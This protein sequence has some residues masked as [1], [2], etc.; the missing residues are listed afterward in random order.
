MMNNRKTV[1][2]SIVL[3]SAVGLALYVVSAMRGIPQT[4]SA[5]GSSQQDLLQ[6]RPAT[7]PAQFS[8]GDVQQVLAGQQLE[9]LKVITKGTK[10]V[11]TLTNA[12]TVEDSTGGVSLTLYN[13]SIGGKDLIAAVLTNTG[14]AQVTIDQFIIDGSQRCTVGPSCVIVSLMRPVI[15]L[16]PN[17]VD[18]PMINSTIVLNP[19]E[20]FTA[21]IEPDLNHDGYGA[22]GC[23]SYDLNDPTTHYCVSTGPIT[24]LR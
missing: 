23:Y 6:G 17:P 24:W 8:K 15:L 2:V 14:S 7:P 22:R 11:S 13:G 20:S 16:A 18:K 9:K 19:Q 3:A 12:T 10:Y 4:E 21:F 5:T 1:I